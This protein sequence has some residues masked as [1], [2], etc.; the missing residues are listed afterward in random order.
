MERDFEGKVV[1]ITGAARGLGRAVARRL[2]ARGA[3]LYL[4]DILAD[5]LEET[6]SELAE[7]G[8]RL[9]AVVCDIA[10]RQNCFELVEKAVETFGR[11]DV[12]CNI[13]GI[14]RFAHVPEMTQEEWE[15]VMAINFHAPFYLSQAAIPHLLKTN[16][17]IVISASQ[18]ASVGSAYLV[19]YSASKAAVVQMTRSMA[20]E[21]IHQ[22]I[23]INVVAPGSMRT[24]IGKGVS[25]PADADQGLL[26]R[27]AGLR[28]A[29]DP[30]DVASLIAFVASDQGRAIHGACLAA[31]GGASAG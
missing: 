6:R 29:S 10:K 8:T 22:Q 13:A 19:A 31:D 9:K 28:E 25:L 1:L 5:K 3:T 30:D 12:L 21:Y 11:L 14:V 26:T 18:T 23:R 15:L 4:V 16:G 27:Y 20:M 17:N 7:K 2:A 24:P